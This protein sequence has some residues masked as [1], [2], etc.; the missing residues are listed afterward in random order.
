MCYWPGVNDFIP[1]PGR[2]QLDSG[3]NKDKSDKRNAVFMRQGG[4]F[5]L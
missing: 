4:R 2:V 5:H 3:S 1:R